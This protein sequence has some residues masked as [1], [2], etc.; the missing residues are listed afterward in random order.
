MPSYRSELAPMSG[1]IRW[2]TLVL[3]AI[4]IGFVAVGVSGGAP[5]L[6]LWVGL[7]VAVVYAV[8]WLWWRPAFFEADHDGLRI[9]FPL[10]TRRVAAGD[11]AGARMVTSR[12]LRA[13]FGLA[14]RIGAGGLWGGFGWLW[15][16]RRGRVEFYVSRE[17]RYVLIERREGQPLLVT[18]GDAEGLVRALDAARIG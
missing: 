7:A 5:R 9:R 12:E 4:P 14:L 13:E 6:L 17:D 18:P 3:L 15:T 8:V 11:L 1:L 2:L 16:Q 10:R